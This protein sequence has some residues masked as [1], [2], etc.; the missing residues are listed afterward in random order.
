MSLWTC[1]V[2]FC[3]F[4]LADGEFCF[5][6]FVCCCCFCVVFF[7]FWGGGI[8][9]IFILFYFSFFLWGLV[10][11]PHVSRFIINCILSAALLR[12]SVFSLNIS[13]LVVLGVSLFS[14]C[15]S[16][17]SWVS[18]SWWHILH[19]SSGYLFLQLA[20]TSSILALALNIVL[21]WFLVSL[22]MYFALFL[23]PIL[24]CF[25]SCVL[26]CFSLLLFLSLPWILLELPFCTPLW[27]LLVSSPSFLLGSL[28]FCRYSL[29][30][31]AQLSFSFLLRMVFRV[32]FWPWLI[33]LCM[34]SLFLFIIVIGSRNPVSMYRHSLGIDCGVFRIL[35][36]MLSN[37]LFISSLFCCFPYFSTVGHYW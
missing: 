19:A 25:P 22:S 27:I 29:F 32:L 17:W 5:F 30:S 1:T 8:I 28:V 13:S 37:I 4:F 23:V 26:P 33:W 34:F 14:H 2:G 12:V 35:F 9:I 31:M 11:L 3:G 6:L 24:F 7:F 20:F 16:T 18:S 15:C 21:T 36:K 10:T